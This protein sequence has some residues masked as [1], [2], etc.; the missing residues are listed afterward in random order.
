[1][2]EQLKSYLKLLN[3]SIGVIICHKIF[4]CDFDYSANELYKVEIDFVKDNQDGVA[5]IDLLTKSAFNEN[6]I[7]DFI[8]KKLET[9]QKIVEIRNKVNE[10]FVSNILKDY[11]RKEYT[12]EEINI[13]LKDYEIKIVKNSKEFNTLT[14]KIA[15]L[16]SKEVPFLDDAKFPFI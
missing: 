8:R 11:L 14:V 9:K 7:K 1:M 3:L 15:P 4:F 6:A 12:E 16:K 5:F 2:E 13:A 10:E